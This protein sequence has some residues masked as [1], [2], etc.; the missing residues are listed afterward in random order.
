MLERRMLDRRPTVNNMYVIIRPPMVKW[1]TNSLNNNNQIKMKCTCCCCCTAN[2]ICEFRTDVS[3][4]SSWT[5]LLKVI[6][7][8]FDCDWHRLFPRFNVAFALLASVLPIIWLLFAP[9]LFDCILLQIK[10]ILD[11]K[12]RMDF[13]SIISHQLK[14]NRNVIKILKIMHNYCY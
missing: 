12:K 11:C 9:E 3:T 1:F 4:F 6:S 10:T 14:C 13:Q 8:L 2:C 5:V 7:M